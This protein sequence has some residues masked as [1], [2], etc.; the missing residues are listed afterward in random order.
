VAYDMVGAI[1][2]DSRKRV[3]WAK[4]ALKTGRWSDAIYHAYSAQVIGAKALLLAK[5]VKCNTHKGIINDFISNYQETDDFELA[6]NFSTQV[7]AINQNEPTKDFANQ[8]FAK[9]AT[10]FKKVVV[11]REEQLAEIAADKLVVGKYYNA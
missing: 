4:D 11:K 7:L 3:G 9:A 10:F 6:E 5:D 1:V 2:N 8:Y